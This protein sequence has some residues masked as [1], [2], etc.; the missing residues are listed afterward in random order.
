MTKIDASILRS[1]QNAT[2]VKGA[3]RAR[4]MLPT[5]AAL[6]TLLNSTLN[7]QVV[8]VVDVVIVIR[9]ELG[10]IKKVLNQEC[11]IRHMYLNEQITFQSTVNLKFI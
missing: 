3:V 5:T 11:F 4:L 1:V 9:T 8:I 7:H 10:L 2:N 6:I